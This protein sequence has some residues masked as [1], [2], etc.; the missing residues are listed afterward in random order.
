MMV[1]V[2]ALGG[3]GAVSGPMVDHVDG[4]PLRHARELSRV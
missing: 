2:A 1:L 4:Y 3:F